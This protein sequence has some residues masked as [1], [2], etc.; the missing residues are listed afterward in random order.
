MLVSYRDI[1]VVVGCRGSNFH[2]HISIAVRAYS[3]WRGQVVRRS[4]SLEVRAPLRAL[5]PLL[6]AKYFDI[7][8]EYPIHGGSSDVTRE[9]VQT[10]LGRCCS[11]E[12]VAHRAAS[13]PQACKT[14]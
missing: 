2:V 6:F 4:G 8:L 11:N 12:R 1:G 10:A 13:D 9:Q 5:A 3:D 14:W 7:N